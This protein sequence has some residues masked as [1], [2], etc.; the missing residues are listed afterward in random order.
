[1]DDSEFGPLVID[2]TASVPSD[3]S[4]SLSRT[5]KVT[6]EA[7]KAQKDGNNNRSKPMT[8]TI[9][10]NVTSDGDRTTTGSSGVAPSPSEGGPSNKRSRQTVKRLCPP[11]ERPPPPSSTSSEPVTEEAVAEHLA[12][13]GKLSLKYIEE[14]RKQEHVSQLPSGFENCFG[15][16]SDSVREIHCIGR[17]GRIMRR[18]TPRG[19][20]VDVPRGQ[21][22]PGDTVGYFVEDPTYYSDPNSLNPPKPKVKDTAPAVSDASE[23]TEAVETPSQVPGPSHM[24]PTHEAD[25]L[26]L[27][28]DEDDLAMDTSIVTPAPTATPLKPILR[29][30]RSL[31]NPSMRLSKGTEKRR[32]RINVGGVLIHVLQDKDESTGRMEDRRGPFTINKGIQKAETEAKLNN[33]SSDELEA[34]LDRIDAKAEKRKQQRHRKR[35]PQRLRARAAKENKVYC[36]PNI[37][38]RRTVAGDEYVGDQKPLIKKV[39]KVMAQQIAAGTKI[40]DPKAPTALKWIDVVDRVG[41]IQTG[42]DHDFSDHDSL[43]PIDDVTLNLAKDNRLINSLWSHSLSMAIDDANVQAAQE[44]VIAHVEQNDVEEIVADKNTVSSNDS[45]VT[46]HESDI[47]SDDTSSLPSTSSE[48]DR[49]TGAIAGGVDTA[50]TAPEAN[51]TPGTAVVAVVADQA[52]ENLDG[53]LPWEQYRADGD[54]GAREDNVDNN[55]AVDLSTFRPIEAAQH[56]FLVN[57]EGRLQIHAENGEADQT[58]IDQLSMG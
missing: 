46:D 56:R 57:V 28:A 54:D 13:I 53:S 30:A 41:E 34:E 24:T 25:I 14:H 37:S 3:D 16:G 51:N 17:G 7:I 32:V 6:T 5:I 35:S 19:A 20:L 49:S 43:N 27:H 55:R 42:Q 48:S 18:F 15:K 4:T 26:E 44:Y 29:P 8:I 50:N 36:G 40:L 10:T 45:I 33:M 12:A 47:S 38:K 39:V 58:L 2:E 11:L 21:V 1:M 31:E 23:V 52:P 9:D 22:Q